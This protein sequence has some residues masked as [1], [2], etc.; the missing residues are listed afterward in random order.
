M[1]YKIIND[2]ES[3]LAERDEWTKICDSM[4]DSTPFQTWEWNYIWWKNNES[5]ESLFVI[6]AFEGKKVYGYAPLVVK[7]NTVE[8]I[9]GR[10]MDY[11]AFVVV[12]KTI[13]VIEGFIN[14]VLERKIA[15]AFQEMPSSTSQLHIV[16]KILEEKKKYL[17]H[18][19]TR[20]AYIDRKRY[21]NFD[22]Y[23]KMLSQS[24]RNKTI[25]EGL[26]KNLTIS[27]EKVTD[28]LMKEIEE[29][30]INRQEIR[31][32]AP[33]IT[34]SFKIIEQMNAEGLLDVYFIRNEEEA[35]GFLVCMKHKNSKYIWL[36]AFKNQYRN[37]F[38]GQLLFYQTIKDGFEQECPKID[39]MRGDYDFKMRWECLLST[40][41]TVYLFNS[42]VKYLKHKIVFY[43]R[44]RLKKIVYSYPLLERIY[45]KHAK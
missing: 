36:V 1:D 7:N 6:K 18:K 13:P 30:Y 26:K 35:V 19:T 45:K 25:K 37:S 41:Y 12:H 39:F 28:E 38:P 23:F 32:G 10:D 11:G 21:E 31:G 33:D 14:F 16:Q 9:G 27:Q 42:N 44:P 34:W 8:F 5:P 20:V 43:L 2:A 24:M 22:S 40:N 4:S 3:L 17:V 15:I 29:I